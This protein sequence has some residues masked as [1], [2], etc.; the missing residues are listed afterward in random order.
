VVVASTR[1][2]SRLVKPRQALTG[3]EL[4][5]LALERSPT[6]RQ[7][8]E[9]VCDLAARCN[10]GTPELDPGED[11]VLLLADPREAYVLE[12]AG[13]FWALLECQH[14]RAVS[15]VSLIR[16]DWQ[17]LAPGLAEFVIQKGWWPD[18]GTKVDFAGSLADPSVNHTW[19]LRRWSK[20]TLALAQQN[21]AID[22]Y[23][24]RRMLADHFDANVRRSPL[25]PSPV[26]PVTS[27]I[28]ACA[29]NSPALAWFAAAVGTAQLFMPLIVGADIP[30]LWRGRPMS[31]TPPRALRGEGLA[32]LCERLQAQIDQD[33]EE[34]LVE[35][36]ALQHEDTT[37]LT[38]L[39]QALMQ[40]HVELWDIE[41]AEPPFPP[42][43]RKE[44]KEDLVS[45]AFG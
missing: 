4:V 2:K 23:V 3:T 31:L 28:A 19:G 16:Q 33:T 6:A 15:D 38:R 14:V 10:Q 45:F 1:W 11:H 26:R 32:A 18:D 39:G 34:F 7:A 9:V 12:V 37:A 8:V 22:P 13:P 30:D 36:R 29:D 40:R 25:A 43:R 42:P 5:R 27:M 41:S 44:T 24:L 21:G 35:A 17:R 20:A